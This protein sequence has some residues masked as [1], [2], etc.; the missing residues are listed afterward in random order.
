MFGQCVMHASHHVEKQGV[1]ALPYQPC[2]MRVYLIT[3]V[4]A[5]PYE[6]LAAADFVSLQRLIPIKHLGSSGVTPL[7]QAQSTFVLTGTELFRASFSMCGNTAT[8]VKTHAQT[9][10]FPLLLS[11]IKCGCDLTATATLFTGHALLP[12]VRAKA[13]TA[14]VP[15][16]TDNATFATNRRSGMLRQPQHAA[17]TS[18][19]RLGLKSSLWTPAPPSGCTKPS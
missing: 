4:L 5:L 10:C 13:R 7:R 1:L 3:H 2:F 11:A 17:T 16:R 12:P 6:S 15:S 8:H 14:E 18:I 19:S 9:A